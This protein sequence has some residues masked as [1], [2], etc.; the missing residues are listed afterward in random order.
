MKLVLLFFFLLIFEITKSQSTTDTFSIKIATS[1]PTVLPREFICLIDKKG[2]QL[3]IFYSAI[4]SFNRAYF[5]DKRVAE[6]LHNYVPFDTNNP[7]PYLEHQHTLDSLEKI[8]SY[9]K[10]DSLLLK[11]ADNLSFINIIYEIISTP[12]EELE[13]REATKKVAVLDGG[14]YSFIIKTNKTTKYVYAY[15]LLDPVLHSLLYKL[16][17]EVQNIYKQNKQHNFLDKINAVSY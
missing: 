13:N 10:K 4:D 9:Y 8:Y 6:L 12:K 3:K 15:P 17:M 16:L 14:N 1:V 11:A 2:D 7:K 5:K